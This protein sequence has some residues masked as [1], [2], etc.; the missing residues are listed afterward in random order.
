MIILFGIWWG[1]IGKSLSNEL[2]Y[3]ASAASISLDRFYEHAQRLARFNAGLLGTSKQARR[4]HQ[5]GEGNL[6]L[7]QTVHSALRFPVLFNYEDTNML[8]A[9]LLIQPKKAMSLS[10]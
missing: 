2:G 3:V 6:L 1:T 10:K 9:I 7:G 4:W 8:M 5:E